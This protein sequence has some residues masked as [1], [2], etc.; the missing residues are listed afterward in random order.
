MAGHSNSY[1][2]TC[3]PREDSDQPAHR[4]RLIRVYCVRMKTL[5]ILALL[6]STHAFFFF[7]LFF[8]FFFVFFCF[9]FLLL[10]LFLL[11]LFFCKKNKKNILESSSNAPV[12]YKVPGFI[13]NNLHI[14]KMICTHVTFV[15]IYDKIT[16]SA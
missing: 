11:L 3:A 10:L 13:G 5:W 16:K 1:K 9:F 6:I 4:R 14:D 8:F 12:L 2:T 15:R 7:F